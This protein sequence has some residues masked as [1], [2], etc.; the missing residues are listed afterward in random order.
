MADDILVTISAQINQLLEGFNSASEATAAALSKLQDQVAATSDAIEGRLSSSAQQASESI[1]QLGESSGSIGGALEDV[2]DKFQTAFDV[3]GITLAYEAVKK[4]VE[5]VNELAQ[6]AVEME[7]A[8]ETLGITTSQFQGLQV[9]AATTGVPVE[10]LERSMMMLTQRM[11]Q[12]AELGG[13]QAEK[14][15]A[16]GLSVDKLR[17]PFFNIIE[18]MEQL[19]VHANTNQE[20]IGLLGARTAPIIP[21]LREMAQNHDLLR[22]SAEK[23][24]ALLP[25]E[26]AALKEYHATVEVAKTQFENFASRISIAV[27][28]ALEEMLRDFKELASGGG[29]L[30]AVFQELVEDL[31]SVVIIVTTAAYAFKGLIDVVGDA[32]VVIGKWIGASAAVNDAIHRMDFNGARAIAKD[33]SADIA[34]SW[35]K[36]IAD[37]SKDADE[38]DA[39]V[40][41]M[42]IAL[43]GLQ[44][45]HPNIQK[46][47]EFPKPPP[48]LTKPLE[49]FA[50]LLE[51][52][53]E[54][55]QKVL[56]SDMKEITKSAIDGA[57]QQEDAAV[58]SIDRQIEAVHALAA[59]HRIS[60]DQELAQ[61][62]NLLNQ[63]WSAQQE[64][65][66]KA[67][68]LASG[69]LKAL[70][71]LNLQQEKSYQQHLTAMQKAQET[72]T[73]KMTLDWTT[74]SKQVADQFASHITS[75]LKGTETFGH[76]M[77]AI[78]ASIFEDIVKRLLEWAAQWVT[79]HIIAM[80]ATKTTGLG[81]VTTNASVAATAAMA[82]V[83]AIP[84]WGW[85]AAP[86]V[87][88][89][90]FATAMS[91]IPSA[92]GGWDVPKDML[93]FVH[94]DEKILP[95]R[96]SQGLDSLIQ[97]GSAAQSV[98]HYHVNISAIDT[99]SGAEFIDKH[100]GTI[101]QKLARQ[102][103]RFHSSMR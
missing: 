61:T 85:A 11:M 3:A 65:Y 32:F 75:M 96:F 59:T 99:Q 48:D 94:K 43:S 41:R 1:K 20:L 53:E 58:A 14:F 102:M 84:F 97:S 80:A 25:S 90:T 52:I 39:A 38:G 31:K 56:E 77:R 87:G 7:H 50:A 86:G 100:V 40:A 36:M 8:S 88:A 78:F 60:V 23:V 95:A 27:V 69:D 37:F 49:S 24:N 79:Q 67:E 2:K 101:A 57:K 16:L 83:A 26:I 4:V 62:T 19:G 33:A 92:A 10:R 30:D 18:A 82:S 42:R 55:T 81:E 12:A 17:D 76:A 44:E 9:A 13:K 6:R 73:K 15:D 46:K 21:V 28:P 35:K 68:A 66:S 71:M 93:A 70:D 51:Q 5:S 45:V 74:M 34:A 47:D 54:K 98:N 103:S 29:P 91:Y 72:A 63:K 89:E 64:Y 22:E